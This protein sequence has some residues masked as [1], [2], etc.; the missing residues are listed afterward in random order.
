VRSSF[1]NGFLG[2]DMEPLPSAYTAVT[3]NREIRVR[4][5]ENI[6]LTINTLFAHVIGEYKLGLFPLTV[7]AP[8]YY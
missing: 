3:M 1:T 6:L 7:A 4:P 5:A 2:G 8:T